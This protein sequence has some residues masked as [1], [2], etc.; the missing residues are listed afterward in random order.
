MDGN[1][2]YKSDIW[3]WII[4]NH[5]KTRKEKMYQSLFERWYFVTIS[6]WVCKNN[7]NNSIIYFGDKIVTHYMV[8]I[9]TIFQNWIIYKRHVY[10]LQSL[11]I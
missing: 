10:I 1:H 9:F 6:T 4:D 2:S 11:N 3:D 8:G 5:S 7:N